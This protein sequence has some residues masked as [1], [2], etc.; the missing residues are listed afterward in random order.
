VY[1]REAKQRRPLQNRGPRT[2]AKDRLIDFFSF[3]KQKKGAIEIK[4]H[5]ICYVALAGGEAKHG[6]MATPLWMIG[7]VGAC[8]QLRFQICFSVRTV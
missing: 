3:K 2:S 7:T 8:A 6:G 1:S 4:S 5:F